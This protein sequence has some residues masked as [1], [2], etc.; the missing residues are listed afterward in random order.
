MNG[1]VKHFYDLAIDLKT[2]GDVDNVRENFSNFF[3]N[4][5]FTIARRTIQKDAFAGINSG[6]QPA[7]KIISN[8]QVFKTL[9]DLGLLYPL[10]GDF[11]LLDTL[12][13]GFQ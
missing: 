6:P 7:D 1:W 9:V 5:C 2:V 8:N 3:S 13:I 4:C 11:L 10:I 12:L